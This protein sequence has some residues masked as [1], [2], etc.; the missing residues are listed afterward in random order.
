VGGGGG[1]RNWIGSGAR[2]RKWGEETGE[3]IEE[4]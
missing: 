4:R 2:R 3:S 1:G